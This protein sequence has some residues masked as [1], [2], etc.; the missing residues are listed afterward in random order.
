MAANQCDGGNRRALI[1]DRRAVLGTDV[2]RDLRALG[3][4]VDIFCE[5][6][7]P[8]LRSRYFAR[9]IP[10]PSPEQYVET[11]ETLL[12]RS[13]YDAMF[14]CSEEVLQSIA[15]RLGS[16][17]YGIFLAPPEQ[18]I[19]ML[20]GKRAT[21]SLAAEHDLSV[22]RTMVPHNEQELREMA[23]A[24]GYPLVVKGEKGE[25]S[26]NVRVVHEPGELAPKYRTVLSNESSY[27]GCPMLQEFIPGSQYSVGGLYQEGAPLRVC[28]YRKIF[29]YPLEGGL[30]AKA[31]TERPPRLLNDAFRMFRA[32]RY[33]GLGQIQFIRDQRDGLFK[34]ME[35]NPRIW[36]SIGLAA[37]AG[38]DLF[39]PY[40]EL[41]RG[42]RIEPDLNFRE[43]V[44]YQRI[45]VQLRLISRQPAHMLS[46]VRDCL[47]SRVHSDMDLTDPGP[48]IPTV[49][50][51]QRLLH[52]HE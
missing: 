33:T 1:V 15:P 17:E 10:A 23:A 49:K 3:W 32:L 12:R 4:E 22:P 48:Y 35:V 51:L 19:R 44:E 36:A 42:G 26:E 14:L 7:S 31:V 34:F 21:L 30:T 9:R 45:T 38:V 40:R 39:T 29:T 52:R 6:G 5:P 28:A 25:A 20:A 2:C 13:A 24:L 47:N 8:A 50:G 18:T 41:V 43:G 46:F 27:N 37:H 11:L 16:P